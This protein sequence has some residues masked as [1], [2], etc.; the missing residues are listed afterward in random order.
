MKTGYSRFP[1]AGVPRLN[2][3]CRSNANGGNKLPR[4]YPERYNK[5][6][7]RSATI[8]FLLVFACIY[9]LLIFSLF[10]SLLRLGDSL[11]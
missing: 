3:R 2:F 8:S 10:L 1:Q 9:V 11:A 5:N 6:G 4:T 7:I